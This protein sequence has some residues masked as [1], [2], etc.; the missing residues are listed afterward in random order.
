M[1]EFGDDAKQPR[2]TSRYYCKEGNAGAMGLLG[3]YDDN[4]ETGIE[5]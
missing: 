4:E 3:K 5:V 2:R 1:A